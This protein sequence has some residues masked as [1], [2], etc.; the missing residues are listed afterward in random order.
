MK[1]PDSHP[2]GPPW[3]LT[4]EVFAMWNRVWGKREKG[5][6]CQFCNH[7]FKE[8]DSMTCTFSNFEGQRGGNPMTCEECAKFPYETR[9]AVWKR[10]DEPFSLA[11]VCKV[12]GIDVKLEAP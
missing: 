4:P 10:L 8:G 6:R 11:E 3:R 5:F 7:A 2:F 9:L 1:E 12:M